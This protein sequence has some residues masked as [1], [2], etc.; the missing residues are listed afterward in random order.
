MKD[1]EFRY[2]IAD[3]ILN[4]FYQ[5]RTGYIEKQDLF[6]DNLPNQDEVLAFLVSEGLLDENPYGYKI[7]Y[8][9]RIAVDKG[10]L[11]G[12]WKRKRIMYICTIVAA[13]AGV[14]AILVAFI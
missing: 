10:G 3:M 2:K 7:T 14:I 6:S 8:K 9:G 1:I 13:I 11:Y 4:S 12:A 5:N